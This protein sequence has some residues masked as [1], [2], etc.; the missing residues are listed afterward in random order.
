[1]TDQDIGQLTRRVFHV[2]ESSNHG[3][4]PAL[5]KSKDGVISLFYNDYSQLSKFF[6][7]DIP[8]KILDFCDQPKSYHVQQACI[9]LADYVR[10][11]GYEIKGVCSF[12]ETP[13]FRKNAISLY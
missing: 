7:L 4:F 8:K 6:D 1:M 3:F 10:K 5:A 2:L 9:S 13:I 11:N 12:L